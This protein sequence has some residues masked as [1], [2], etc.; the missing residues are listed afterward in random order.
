MHRLVS[1]AYRA[2]L[3]VF[4]AA[5]FLA[6]LGGV[7]F[8]NLN[9]EAY[10]NPVPPMVNVV[11]R[12]DGLSPEEVERYVT[13]P[14][15]TGLVGMAGLDHV[16]SQSLFGLSDIKCYFSWDLTYPAAR[17][18]VLN[19]LAMVE[20]PDDTKP[21]ISPRNAIGELFRYT[22]RGKGYSTAELKATE[23]WVLERQFKFVPGVTDV[24]SF[25][26]ETKQY[27]ILVDPFGLRS[28]G[29]SL[30]DLMDSVSQGN[31]N[32]G[33]QRLTLGEQSY[34][35]RGVGLLRNTHDIEDIVVGARE[36]TPTRIS[37]L[38]SV[39]IGHA[40]R[41]GIV[42]QDEN[43]DIV[44]GIVLM[45]YGEQTGPTLEGIH[46]KLDQLKH[47]NVLPP[48]VEI[49]PYYD[50]GE[51]VKWTTH[52]VFENA[53]IGV[54]LVTAILYLF[55]GSIRAALIA[56]VNIPIALGLAAVGMITLGTP[57]NLISLGAVDFGIV[58]DS[59][60]VMVESLLRNLSHGGASVPTEA[61]VASAGRE[62]ARP[63]LFGTLILAVAFIP[64]FT[65]KG[66]SGVLFKP[67]AIT[68]ALAIGGAT[69]LAVTLTPAAV[70]TLLGKNPHDEPTY[71]VRILEKWFERLLAK[72]VAAP[73]RV[74]II[75]MIPS[76]LVL[77]LFSHLGREF[78]PKLEE[79][80]LY[81]RA[82]LPA[83]I[84]LERSAEYANRMRR[85]IRGC[86]DPE[87]ACNETERKF[88]EL[89]TVTSQVGRPDDGTD[90]AGFNNVELFAPLRPKDEWRKGVTKE[91]IIDELS[92]SLE[93]A[94]PGTTFSFSQMIRDNVEEALSGVKGENSVKVIGADIHADE[95]YADQIAD[96]L[97][98]VPG[99]RDVGIFRVLGQPTV[100]IE[101]DRA[102]SARYGFNTGDVE[103]V[104]QAAVGGRAVTQVYEGD[105]KFDLTVRWK[106]QFRNSVDSIREI[107]ITTKDGKSVALGEIAKITVE[108][109]ASIVYREDGARYVA[110]KF[111]VRDRD[112]ASTVEEARAVV[113][114]EVKIPYDV[115]LA[116][117]GE[118]NELKEAEGR[119]RLVLP[120]ALI[121]IALLVFVAVRRFREWLVVM[122]N[123]PIAAG[124]GI[125]LLFITG[126]H[127][128]VSAAMGFV[129]ALG[130]A[131][132]DGMIVVNHS[133][134][135]ERQGIEPKEA[136][137]RA[138]FERFR[139][140]VMTALV[141]MAGL[142]PA[143][144]SSGIGSETQKPLAL[145]VIGG[146]AML[147]TVVRVIQPAL[148]TWLHSIR[149]KSGPRTSIPT[150]ED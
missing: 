39:A 77:G 102:A 127:F 117:D 3:I 63:I 85:I 70:P 73:K 93:K 30:N 107:T 146:C 122:V 114:R 103:A 72:V 64:L 82:Q 4:G 145:V 75:V 69:I 111:S 74:L 34:A 20:L 6:I 32:V 135:L 40:P 27:Q 140:C 18:E 126:T 90:T 131:V 10:P 9:I 33:G 115:H 136:S 147:A 96:S 97:A 132:Q 31:R 24:T 121:G 98:K 50:R 81:V 62:V 44:Q 1:A 14:L 51:L 13:T 60:V 100:R 106:E 59:T 29:L 78:L 120:A 113:N 58:V 141:P 35:V 86:P 8:K 55:M 137:R 12:P 124:G 92:A 7:A 16:R 125:A 45:R 109:G 144:V 91:Q 87:V 89:M 116:W 67:M 52:T 23:D 11:T 142:L 138:V 57:A 119:L 79:G 88:P 46:A 56:A 37:D 28:Y 128:S 49:V 48:G 22:V 38:A 110:V 150:P 26:G 123:I 134:E 101:P 25:G 21:E 47:G 104:V 95:A 54:L 118:L 148:L 66:V 108:D 76:I 65:M 129:S 71:P 105:R 41:L 99:V 17:Q 112:L 130:I 139:P 80:N 36:G 15:E 53:V 2:R 149:L 84:S 68:Y 61:K 19:R 83:S 94:F 143:A 133:L 42:G 43:P 5:L